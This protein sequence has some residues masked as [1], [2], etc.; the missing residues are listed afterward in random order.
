MNHTEMEKGRE[1]WTGCRPDPASEVSYSEQV[2]GLTNV[3]CRSPE[4]RDTVRHLQS[5]PQGRLRREDGLSRG[6]H[7]AGA[8]QEEL[9]LKTK[10]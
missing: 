9:I 2:R 7:T 5:L 8:T 1:V 3:L 4:L 10:Q 6:V